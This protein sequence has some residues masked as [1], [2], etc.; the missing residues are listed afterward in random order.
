MFIFLWIWRHFWWKS[1]CT[2]LTRAKLIKTPRK[3]AFICPAGIYTVVY[4]HF[5]PSTDQLTHTQTYT[6]ARRWCSLVSILC[7]SQYT[8]KKRGK[9]NYAGKK[10]NFSQPNTKNGKKILKIVFQFRC[11]F[12]FLNTRCHKNVGWKKEMVVKSV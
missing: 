9:K 12:F 6:F 2:R 7:A 4:G 5:L 1:Q 11:N 3:L 10:T 8:A